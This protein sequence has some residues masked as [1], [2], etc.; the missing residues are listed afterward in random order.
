MEVKWL[1][2]RSLTLGQAG[3]FHMKWTSCNI[4]G[5]PHAQPWNLSPLPPLAVRWST[6]R[7]DGGGQSKNQMR[8]GPEDFLSTQSFRLSVTESEGE[9]RAL[10]Y[11][12]YRSVL[13]VRLCHKEG[14]LAVLRVFPS[15]SWF[16]ASWMHP[17]LPCRRSAARSSCRDRTPLCPTRRKP[18]LEGQVCVTLKVL[19][20]LSWL[21]F[22]TAPLVLFD[23]MESCVGT[24]ICLCLLLCLLSSLAFL[25][26]FV[27]AT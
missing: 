21:F 1:L 10:V 26:S 9:S 5:G 17:L 19:A 22:L 25:V 6:E 12:V 2:L 7:W 24:V 16:W 15:P 18:G 11:D 27:S 8:S 3:R 13:P 14:H 23:H 20:F 4:P